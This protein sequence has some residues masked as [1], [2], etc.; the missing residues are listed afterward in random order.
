MLLVRQD[1]AS[2]GC[3]RKVTKDLRNRTLHELVEEFSAMLLCHG[4]ILEPMYGV[5]GRIQEPV[6]TTCKD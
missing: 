6:V 5:S 1:T 3:T 2:R 4:E